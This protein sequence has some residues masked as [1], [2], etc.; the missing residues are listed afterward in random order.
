[1]TQQG[2]AKRIPLEPVLGALEEARG[3]GVSRVTFLGGEP[4]IQPSFLP[5]LKA[6]VDLGFSDIVIFTNLVRG[7]EPKFLEQV[8]ALGRFTWRV[9]IQGGDEETHDR[10]VGRPGAWAKIQQ[11]LRWLGER[12]HHLTANACIN[13]ESYRSVEGY[14]DLV[15]STGLRQLHI[16]MVRP[17][18]TGERTKAYQRSLLVPY[19]VMA[20]YLG[21]MLDAFDAWDPEFEVNL[22]N[23][24]FCLLPRHAHRI[25]HGG[26][27]TLTVTTDDRGDLGR[28]WD[29]Y[30]HQGSDKVLAE[31]CAQCGFRS[32]CRG[33]PAEYADFHGLDELQPVFQEEIDELDPRVRRW[34]DTG[35]RPG[36]TPPPNA[37]LARLA[38]VVRQ[39]REGAPWVGWGLAGHRALASGDGVVV[40]L[41]AGDGSL[42]VCITTRPRFKMTFQPGPGTSTEQARAPIEAIANNL[43]GKP[44]QPRVNLVPGNSTARRLELFI[45]SGCNLHCSFC[46]ESDRIKRK[47]FMDWEE[48][49]AKLD[50]A[51]RA[52]IDVVQFMGGEATLHPRF[53]DALRYTKELGLGTYVITNLS[54]WQQEDFAQAV[55]PWLDEVM[56]SMHAWGEEQGEAVTGIRG[57]W[58]GFGEAAAN[59][60]ETLRGR[61]RCSTVLTRYN[62]DD[63]ERIGE[64]LMRFGPEAWIMGCAVPVVGTREEAL[65]INLSLT[66]LKALR[67]RFE[68]LSQRCAEAGCKLIFFAMPSCI[69][70]PTLWNDSHDV[71]L[72]DQD[73]TD[74]APA[75]VETVT[76]W[77]KADDLRRPKAVTLGRTRAEPCGGCAREHSCGGHFSSYFARFGAGELEPVRA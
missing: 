39:L 19:E 9:S 66:E 45:A 71:W 37:A 3:Q 31:T 36:R 43:S 48:V 54:R 61:V 58:R 7:R 69:I 16:D 63:L 21:R 77:S 72:N 20:P 46:C 44:E 64:E 4:T 62:V 47:R 76:F 28:V 11:G 5:A 33:V 23:F 26:Q 60:R 41:A 51:K 74:G 1:M 30:A 12:G 56:V 13:R 10:V 6:A 50:A 32:E 29:K 15:R 57:W 24:P 22:G 14:V 40:T 27:D 52:G 42:D 25:A 55:G 65:D 34:L 49:T 70:G 73:L 2:L 53:P 67:S 35:W 75:E 38:R 17:D 18:S 8:C 68:A 59:A